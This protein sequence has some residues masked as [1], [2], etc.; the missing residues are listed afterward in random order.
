MRR[1]LK[2]WIFLFCAVLLFLSC[3]RTYTKEEIDQIFKPITS[4][5]GIKIV[6]EI[7]ADFAPIRNGGAR[8][9]FSRIGQ[10]D[11]RVLAIYPA[12]LKKAFEKYPVQVIKKNLY[13]I[14]FAKKMEVGGLEYG[15]TYDSFRRII[16]L[17]NDG[18]QTNDRSVATIHHEFSSILLDRYGFFLNPWFGQNPKGFKYRCE[19]YNNWE[20]A[21]NGTSLVGTTADYEKGFLNSYSKTDFENDFNE[22]SRNIFTYPQK[23]KQIMNQYPRVRGK[24]LVFLEFYHK[25]DPIFTE[26]YLLGGK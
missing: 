5:Y 9:Q 18:Q 10:V 17:V 26:E 7:N 6:Y 25:I 23:F 1:V 3:T 13:A 8:E 2:E 11:S 14:Y 19:I 16:Y 15:G 21:Y 24:F 12:I 22:Y 20:G 4:K